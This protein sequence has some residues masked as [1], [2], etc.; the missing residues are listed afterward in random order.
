MTY[1]L[2]K[3]AFKVSD[4]ANKESSNYL[5]SL[6]HSATFY[7]IGNLVLV[8]AIVSEG[9]DLSV[10]SQYPVV[11]FDFSK[12]TKENAAQEENLYN[13]NNPKE[14]KTIDGGLPNGLA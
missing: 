11:D 8:Y 6:C 2:V 12:M 14:H 3:L 9:T 5:I 7:Y 13:I 4:M 1:K 10:L